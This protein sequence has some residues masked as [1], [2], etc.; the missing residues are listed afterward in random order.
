MPGGILNLVSEGQ[1]NVIL[2]SNPSTTFFKCAYK[3]YTNFG[4]QKFRVD[5]EGTKT[6]SLIE[7]TEFTFK[8]PRYADLLMDTYLVLHLPNIWS[9][10]IPPVNNTTNQYWAPYE[11]RWIQNI[12]AKIISRITITCG[13]QT[14][15]EYSGDYLLAMAQRDFTNTQYDKFK[16]G[17]GQVPELVDP[18]NA[19]SRSNVY[20]N[21][22]WNPDTVVEP[23]IPAT[24]LYIPLNAWFCMNSQ[25]AFPLTALQYNQLQIKISLRPINQLFQIRDVMD[26]VNNY[27][28]VAP[29]FNLEYMQFYR[30]TQPPP[31]VQLA[32]SSYTEKRHISWD[33]SSI[34]LNCTYAFLSDDERVVFSKNEQKYLFKKLQE[35]VFYNISGQTKIDIQSLGMVS[36]HTFYFQRSDANLRNEW[37]NYTNWPYAYMPVNVIPAPTTGTYSIS[38]AYG[39]NP[40]QQIT[41]S[42]PGVNINNT[43]TGYFVTQPIDPQNI[44][45]ILLTLAILFDGAYR[46]NAQPAGVYDFIEKYTRTPGNAPPGLYVYNYGLDSNYFDLAPSGAINM[47]RF[48][49]IEFEISTTLPPLDPLAQS[50]EVCDPITNTFSGVNKPTWRVYVYTYNLHLFE[51]RYNVLTFVG[52]NCG[53]LWAS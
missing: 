16:M 36:T 9:T 40:P 2:N 3:K 31:D 25:Q 47:S 27:P 53:L 30:F 28:Y 14:I 41:V 7:E 35:T 18:A 51:E 6:Y 13:N 38:Y 44:R 49:H 17:I 10:I 45:P 21:A 50:I 42:G 26:Q 33:A 39:T 29:N 15:N 23:S 34:Y 48:T 52:G 19:H 37:S 5:Y 20:P 11:F 8:I 1:P 12:G 46:E 43:S 4:L 24:Q 22:F 32:S